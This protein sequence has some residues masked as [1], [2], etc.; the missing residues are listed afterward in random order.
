MLV[1]GEGGGPRVDHGASVRMRASAGMRRS[2][3]PAGR[4]R[5]S[6]KGADLRV[7]RDMP[8]A[9]D[10]SRAF[11][12]WSSVSTQSAPGG[13][14]TPNLLIRKIRRRQSSGSE[15]SPV[16]GTRWLAIA[17]SASGWGHVGVS[18]ITGMDELWASTAERRRARFVP[19]AGWLSVA[20]DRFAAALFAA[21]TLPTAPPCL[22]LTKGSGASVHRPRTDQQ[23]S[24]PKHPRAY[25]QTS[26]GQPATPTRSS[27]C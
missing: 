20:D 7:C 26:C 3:T 1:F 23:P 2:S 21:P 22:C 13:I 4:S 11:R 15:A 5:T 18:S 14:R 27:N 6:R 16:D 24:T 12:A 10:I 17:P 8:N 25:R 9:P 19:L